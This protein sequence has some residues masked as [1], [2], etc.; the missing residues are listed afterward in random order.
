MICNGQCDYDEIHYDDVA[1]KFKSVS[2]GKSELT[3][4]YAKN[5]TDFG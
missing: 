2:S 5:S 3:F 1:T 4:R